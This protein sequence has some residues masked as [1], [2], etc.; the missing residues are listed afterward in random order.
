MELKDKITIEIKRD[1]LVDLMKNLTSDKNKINWLSDMLI[2]WMDFHQ[3]DNNENCF[4]DTMILQGLLKE[5]INWM[6]EDYWELTME[7]TE[8]DHPFDYQVFK[9]MEVV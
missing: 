6:M 1:K 2:D 4:L 9:E 5:N 3:K 8:P 7:D